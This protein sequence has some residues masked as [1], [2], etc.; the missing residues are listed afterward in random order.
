MGFLK[1]LKNLVTRIFFS[2]S[3]VA[4]FIIIVGFR[5]TV[6]LIEFD[7]KQLASVRCSTRNVRCF[8]FSEEIVTSGSRATSVMRNSP[9]T[10]SRMPVALQANELKSNFEFCAIAR[11][12]V[13]NSCSP[14]P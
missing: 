11:N 2:S 6:D 14:M 13:I 10:C 9:S 4:L 5:V 12:V 7:I 3:T 1:I 8:S